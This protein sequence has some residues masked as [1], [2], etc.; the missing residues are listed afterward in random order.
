MK[1]NQERR[2]AAL[3]N[4]RNAVERPP[5]HVVSDESEIT[6][7]MQGKVYIGGISPDDWDE[8]PNHDTQNEN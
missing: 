1:A 3:E 2:I 6:P 4:H 5:Y 8:K 7:E